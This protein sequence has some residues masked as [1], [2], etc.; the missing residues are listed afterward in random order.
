MTVITTHGAVI[1]LSP[2]TLTITPTALAASLGSQQ[3]V[4]AL[5]DISSVDE[6]SAP[7]PT[8]TGV[9]GLSNTAAT[10]LFAPG[11]HHEQAEFITLIQAALQ[12]ELP[13]AIPGLN[14]AA[15]DV[16]T[17]NSDWGSICQIGIALVQDGEITDTHCWLCQPPASLA[18]F[19][20]SN[21]AI[22]GIQPEDVATAPSFA[23]ILPEVSTVVGQLPLVAHNA[24]F[25]FTAILRACAASGIPAPQWTFACSLAAARSA[26][27]GIS[28]HR[29]PVVATHLGVELRQHHD[30]AADAEASAGIIIALAMRSHNTG[31]LEEVF[32]QFG[33][34]MGNLNSE[35]VYPVLSTMPSQR[36]TATKTT[37]NRGAKRPAR[38]AKAATPDTI[39]E[40][41]PDAD[42]DHPLYGHNITLTGD[43]EPFDKGLL[44]EKM[45]EAGATIGKNVTKKT[46]MLVMGPW[47]S[48]TSK[49]KRA[50]QLIEEGQEIE[51][52]QSTRLIDV[53][54]L[55]VEEE[56]PF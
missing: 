29:L 55:E 25:D 50:E 56:P 37:S 15:I 41:N 49:Q 22:H 34:T 35:R 19:D 1:D 47:D 20:S 5:A 36:G 42:P 18:H 44:W 21:I 7:T 4:V 43:F 9:V 45:A 32:Q 28:S 48:V 26:K 27:L 17:A 46:T 52:W 33:F 16:E 53:L 40:P 23:D 14:F 38:W 2:T 10:V 30:A 12:G 24:Q 13:K 39:P 6:L 8:A 31:T 11:K 3:V 54:G 51:M